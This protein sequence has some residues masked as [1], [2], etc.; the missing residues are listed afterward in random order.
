MAL[1]QLPTELTCSPKPFIV[2]TGLDVT[3]NAVHRSIWDAFSNN[4][5]PDRVSVTLKCL[6]G[7]HAYP[8]CKTK[9]SSY[10]W[11]IPKGLLKTEWMQK[12]LYQV[13]SVV[14][15]FFEL[16]WDDA[17]WKERHVMCASRVQVVRSA[18]QGR[19]TKVAVVL[20][21]NS[22]PLPPGENLVAA[23]RAATLCS[24]CELS[25]KSLFVLPHTDHLLGYIVRLENAFL[26]LAQSYYHT[27]CRQIKAHKEFLN[28][29]THQLLFPRHQFKIAFLSELMQDPRSALKHYSQAYS[30]IQ[31][32]RSYDTNN[33]EIKLVAGI[34]NYKI[35]HLSFL[36]LSAPL[37]A[38]SQFRR[39]IDHFKGLHGINDLAFEHSAWLANQFMLF[40]KLFEE[41]VSE[42]LAA[43]QTQHPGFYFYQAACYSKGRK[44]LAQS[45]CSSHANEEYPEN[46]PLFAESLEFYGQRPWRQGQQRIDPPDANKEKSGILALQLNEL[47]FDHSSEIISLLNSS[48]THVKKFNSPYFKL[49]LTVLIGEEYFCAGDNIKAITLLKRAISEYSSQHWWMLLSRILAIVLHCSYLIADF[50][51]YVTTCVGALSHLSCLPDE[52]KSAIQMN[53]LNVLSGLEPKPLSTSLIGHKDESPMVSAVPTNDAQEKWN[54]VYATVAKSDLIIEMN[55]MVSFVQCKAQFLQSEIS[56]NSCVRLNVYFRTTCPSRIRFTEL[57]VHFNHPSYDKFCCIQE[58]TSKSPVEL[59]NDVEGKLVF[60]PWKVSCLKFEFPVDVTCLTDKLTI[61]CISLGMACDRSAVQKIQFKWIETCADASTSFDKSSCSTQGGKSHDQISDSKDAYI[62]WNSVQSVMSAKVIQRPPLIEMTIS[63]P[64]PAILDEVYPIEINL[65]S[66][67]TEHIAKKVTLVVSLVNH[68]GTTSGLEGFRLNTSLDD[69]DVNSSAVPSCTTKF[70]DLKPDQSST[71][72]VYLKGSTAMDVQLSCKM[73]YCVEHIPVH[74]CFE[75]DVVLNTITCESMLT[76]STDISL[77]SPLSVSSKLLSGS[78]APLDFVEIHQP[79]IVRVDSTPATKWPLRI[80]SAHLELNSDQSFRFSENSTSAIDDVNLGEGEVLV[81]CI[82]LKLNESQTVTEQNLENLFPGYYVVK[83]KRVGCSDD[84]PAVTTKLP[85]SKITAKSFPLFVKMTTPAVGILHSETSIT[86][87][88]SNTTAFS[89]T[90]NIAYDGAEAFM[91]SGEKSRKTVVMP[92]STYS[93]TYTL[94]PLSLGYQQLPILQLKAVDIRKTPANS[95]NLTKDLQ[96]I[97]TSSLITRLFIKPLAV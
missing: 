38:I 9:R 70:D 92:K 26:E 91:F 66:L 84:I 46:D 67:E 51:N 79:F 65:K 28:K 17:A 21:Q 19:S 57:F 83:W 44:L 74:S 35:C 7:D 1:F 73:T 59:A 71:V 3:Y 30:L 24:A 90:I 63:H 60:E 18:L 6:P 82:S 31:E 49:Q 55:A 75:S 64:S 8:K 48:I 72:V 62:D 11:Y 4:R 54:S 56:V 14:V 87:H 52:D 95:S 53:L 97:D 88:I 25:A 23:E 41:A 96:D 43:I 47:K 29:T 40:G 94:Y 58:E 42:G 68:D 85:L 81:D 2:L 61:N 86:Y 10:D 69:L 15:I 93:V 20:I 12:H 34:V 89:Q 39:H 78:F 45:L 16:D 80:I 27:E 77:L 33:L 13:P 76:Q 36:Q 32:L 5:R 37:D 50:Q 22:T